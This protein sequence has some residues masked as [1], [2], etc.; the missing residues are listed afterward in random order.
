[1]IDALIPT[2]LY[3]FCKALAFVAARNRT[4]ER[5]NMLSLCNKKCLL[6]FIFLFI[7]QAIQSNS[8]LSRSDYFPVYKTLEPHSYL[9]T[10]VKDQLH[11]RTNEENKLN[12][13]ALS[14]S[15]F[16]INANIGKNID[17][18]SKKLPN[19]GGN[20]GMIGLLMGDIPDG[21]SFTPTILTART[22][23]YPTSSPTTPLEDSTNIDCE[24]KFGFF[25][26]PATYR[27]RGLRFEFSIGIF[28][29]LCFSVQGGASEINYV[30][31]CSNNLTEAE[32]GCQTLSKADVDNYLMCKLQPI[33]DELELCLENFHKSSIEDIRFNLF[34]RKAIEMNKDA[35]GW[36]RFLLIPHLSAGFT[37]GAGDE[38][39]TLRAFGLPF[40][41]NGHNALGFLGGI[42]L[43]FTETIE[44]GFDVGF[45]YF[46]EKTFSNY[47]LP[48]SKLQK[49]IY[50]FRATVEIHPGYNWHFGLKLNAH[51]F[52]GKLSFYAQWVIIEHMNDKI[53]AC[54][55]A[56]GAFKP[57]VLEKRS[58][59]KAQIINTAL[60]YDVSPHVG[61]GFLWQAPI[62]Q[63]N[64]FRST[65]VMFGIN[66]SF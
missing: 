8:S 35:D 2:V 30:I 50:P 61:L 33:A 7:G 40:G 13:G 65:T 49:G 17:N 12:K 57:E 60:N 62:S 42:N 47:P 29:D 46:F 1:L 27:K 16:G 22:A 31:D 63:R 54:D 19:I 43:D 51:H 18:V 37:I 39:E 38:K 5:S 41:N 21:K 55:N 4:L 34:W 36:P 64:V 45:D 58:G 3:L 44:I 26:F 14:I 24:E 56:D 53:T 66:F 15:P 6:A 9:Y 59:W 11:G 48:T 25:E 10:R 28:D 52:L 23:L 20:W 32:S